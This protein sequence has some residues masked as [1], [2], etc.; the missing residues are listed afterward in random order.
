[1]LVAAWIGGWHLH[2]CD[3]DLSRTSTRTC[4]LCA[5][6]HHPAPQP[7]SLVGSSPLTVVD[8]E[9][10]S[11]PFLSLVSVAHS[12]QIPRGPPATRVA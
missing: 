10:T 5:T 11:R 1:M 7:T 6:L 9:T 3:T 2:L 8:L 12:P 4:P